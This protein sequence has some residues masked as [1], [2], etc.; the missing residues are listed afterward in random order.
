MIFHTFYFSFQTFSELQT[1]LVFD[2]C[3][4]YSWFIPLTQASYLLFEDHTFFLVLYLLF[5]FIFFIR[6]SYLFGIHTFYWSFQFCIFQLSFVW[7]LYIFWVLVPFTFSVKDFDTVK[8]YTITNKKRCPK[9]NFKLNFFRFWRKTLRKSFS[10]SFFSLKR[11]TLQSS[12]SLVS[13][14]ERQ[15]PV[16]QNTIFTIKDYF[17]EIGKFWYSKRNVIAFFRL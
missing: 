4:F 2:F 17:R 16:L 12:V 5:E 3:A 6:V 11:P 7:D 1:Y 9:F 8:N 15:K 13:H 10:M 14:A